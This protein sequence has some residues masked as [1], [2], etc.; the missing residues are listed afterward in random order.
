[1]YIA[2]SGIA[3]VLFVFYNAHILVYM[4]I[5][6]NAFVP[7][8]SRDKKGIMGILYTCFFDL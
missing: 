6:G 8:Y 5:S 7:Y 3:F 4:A 1:M 2:V